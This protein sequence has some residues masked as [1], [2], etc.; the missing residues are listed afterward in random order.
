MTSPESPASTDPPP[1]APPLT[2]P[3]RLAL[4]QTPA[5]LGAAALF[6]FFIGI[7]AASDGLSL[8]SLMI[9]GFSLI[10]ATAAG[11]AARDALE[12]SRRPAERRLLRLESL[13]SRQRRN[14]L[15][16]Y[17]AQFESLEPFEVSFAQYAGLAEGDRYWVTYSPHTNTLWAIDPT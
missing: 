10:P 4:F 6:V 16:R 9:W 14:K 3:Q 5:M 8:D 1:S 2:F 13:A 12:D 11:V 17:Y 7:I 15:R